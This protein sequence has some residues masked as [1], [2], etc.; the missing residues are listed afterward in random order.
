MP[1]DGNFE[2]NRG[3]FD[4]DSDEEEEEPS[5]FDEVG[6]EG[7]LNTLST[8]EVE[9]WGSLV[10]S[11]IT[12]PA[13]VEHEDNM[14]RLLNENSQLMAILQA[15]EEELEKIRLSTEKIKN[16]TA[17]KQA[18]LEELKQARLARE[19]AALEAGGDDEEANG[20]K[21]SGKDDDDDDE[22]PKRVFLPSAE[23][24]VM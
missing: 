6:E 10:W 12:T 16:D 2:P 13:D 21:K 14:A 19:A 4:Y 3:P 5:N 1:A 15:Q 17:E 23:L 24:T 8:S 7:D 18:E 20:G 11:H 22:E 9:E